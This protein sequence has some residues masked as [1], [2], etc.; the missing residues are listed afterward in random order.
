MPAWSALAL[1]MAM[2]SSA[3]LCGRA[4][5]Q[6]TGLTGGLSGI[7]NYS[8]ADRTQRLIDGARK[9]GTL[10]LYSSGTPEDIAAVTY[11]FEKKFGVPVKFWRASSEDILRRAMTESRAS[12]FDVDVADTAGPD[13]EALQREKLLQPIASPVLADLIPQ[14]VAAKRAWIMSRL[15]IFTAGANSNLIPPADAPKSYEELTE[16]KWKGRLGIE[17]DDAGWF[18]AVCGIMGEEKGLKLF[19]DIVAQNGMSVRKGHT[20]LANLVAAGEVPLALTLYGYRIEAMKKAGAPITGIALP[21]VVALP[22]GMAV[23]RRAPHPHAAVLF[24]DFFLGEGQRILAA[25]SNVITNTR[26]QPVPA[27]LAFIDSGKLLDEGDK[28]SK[29]FNDTFAGGGR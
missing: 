2:A 5:A 6:V 8:G 11:A 23:F 12:R 28:W 1:L 3:L 19:R 10:T 17:A 20:L 7:A 24:A 26:V 27:D 29:L 18:L 25:R 9:E 4:H 21:P 15:N 14:A 22:N 13:M 16:R